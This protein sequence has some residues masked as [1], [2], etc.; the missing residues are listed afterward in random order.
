[1]IA[2]LSAPSHCGWPLK[3]PF[4]SHIPCIRKLSSFL[5]CRRGCVN[6]VEWNE[7]GTLLI[8]GSDDNMVGVWKYSAGW[9]LRELVHTG[10]SRNIFAAKF[11]PHSNDKQV[12]SCGLD[13]E[14]RL[15]H[16]GA[17]WQH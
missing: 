9:P 13:G 4:S 2:L 11:V 14:V 12:V 16:L 10:H 5:D 6:T 8:S 17:H 1:M 7:A 15:T 3:I